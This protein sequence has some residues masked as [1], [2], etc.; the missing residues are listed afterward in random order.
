MEKIIT[1]TLSAAIATSVVEVPVASAETAVA[2]TA[3]AYTPMQLLEV[4]D[5]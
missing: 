5:G 1:L 4:K 2:T 3:S